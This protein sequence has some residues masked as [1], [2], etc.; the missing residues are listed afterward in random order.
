MCPTSRT[1]SSLYGEHNTIAAIST[2]QNSPIR[3]D[4]AQDLQREKP[5]GGFLPPKMIREHVTDA[6]ARAA[7]T[8]LHK[9]F[10]R[11]TQ[12]TDD[13]LERKHFSFFFPW[14][15]FTWRIINHYFYSLYL[16]LLFFCHLFF[17]HMLDGHILYMSNWIVL[18]ESCTKINVTHL[19]TPFVDTETKNSV[20][21][22]KQLGLQTVHTMEGKHTL[23]HTPKRRETTE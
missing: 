6:A 11:S 17:L 8:N 12:Q 9:T 10:H 22:S 15:S 7:N 13:V 19:S 2:E 18:Y 23:E 20:Q 3:S 16:D 1:V 4:E 14:W 21:S 5:H